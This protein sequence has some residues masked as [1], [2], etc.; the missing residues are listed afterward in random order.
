MTNLRD[1]LQAILDAVYGDSIPHTIII[2]GPVYQVAK[3]HLNEWHGGFAVAA[4]MVITTFFSHDPDFHDTEQHAEFTAAMVKKNQFLF[5]HNPGVDRK[6]WTGM[7]WS[8]FILQSFTS[9]SQFTKGH[10]KVPELGSKQTSAQTAFALASAAVYHTLT[11]VANKNITFKSIVAGKSQKCSG[12]VTD[13][14]SAVWELSIPKGTQYEFN[15][16]MWSAK[17]RVFLE[18]IMALSDNNFAMIVDEAQAFVKGGKGAMNSAASD[19]EDED[20]DIQDLFTFR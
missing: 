14:D 16:A 20:E 8:P 9:H 19:D 17:T 13:G 2:G 11:L 3:Q 18:P 12:V 6:G 5:M 15:E 7:W 4:L 10:I 1:A